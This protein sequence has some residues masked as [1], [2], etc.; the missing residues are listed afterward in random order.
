M[1]KKGLGPVIAIALLLVTTSLA[2]VSFQTWYDTYQ[3]N[4]FTD[5]ETQSNLA[6]NSQEL[7]IYNLIGSILYLKNSNSENITINKIK[8]DSSICFTNY[9]ISPGISEIDLLD[10][11]ENLT[12]NVPRIIIYTDTQILEKSFFLS[13]I[14]V[15]NLLSAPRFPSLIFT[16]NITSI[17]Y[18]GSINLSWTSNYADTCI[19]SVDWS[20]NQ[21]LSNSTIISN[22][23]STSTYTLSCTG[24]GGSI[25]RSVTINV[26][27]PPAPIL[28]FSV[29]TSGVDYGDDIN[30]SWISSNTDTCTA[31][32]NWSGIK[33]I[34]GT[35]IQI[36]LLSNSTYI[37]NCTGIGG[38]IKQSLTINVGSP[39][40]PLL[41]FTS[42]L[43]TIDY[44]SSVTLNWTSSN[45]DSCIASGDWVGAKAIS[46][47][48]T[49]NNLISDKT[50]ILN[51]MGVGG[52][53]SRSLTITVN[54]PPAP[55]L[56]FSADN[57]S[58]IYDSDI[59]LSWISSNTDTCTGSGDWSGA[60]V[61]SGSQN[62][63]NL[64]SSKTYVLNC[65]GIGGSIEQ[66]VTVNVANALD[67]LGPDSA[68][69][70][71][72]N[73]KTYYLTSSVAWDQTCSGES[74]S[75]SNGI[76]DGSNT[77]ASCSINNCPFG[78]II[79]LC[80]ICSGTSP[81]A[82]E[83]PSD[84]TSCGTIDC[85][86]L[87]NYQIIGTQGATTTSQCEYDNYADL[88][89]SRCELES[90]CKDANSADCGSPTTTT[91]ITAGVC[92][93]VGGCSG[94]TVGSLL[95]Y[96]DGTSC[97][98]SMECQSGSCIIAGPTF[99]SVWDTTKI[100]TG[101][102]ASTQ[103]ALPL[104]SDGTY[105]F[106][107][108]WGD[109]N[110][111]TITTWN[112]AEVIH[113]YGSEGIYEINITGT[114]KG[115]R[116][117]DGGDKL[118]LSDVQEWGALNLGNN[119][120]YFAGC[121]NLIGTATDALNLTGTTTLE[122][123]FGS[124]T[125]FNGAIGNWNVSNVINMEL[126]FIGA[127][128][129]NQDISNWDVSTVEDMTGMFIR[130][131][132]FDQNI[133]GWDVSNVWEMDIMFMQSFFD[134]D[135]SGWDVSGVDN[136]EMMFRDSFFDQDISGWDVSNVFFCMLFDDNSEP[137]WSADE[138]PTFTN[139]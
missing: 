69:I 54:L 136:M 128:S 111:N 67:C 39:P 88:T 48:E 31:S 32:G 66:S 95:N 96:A 15:I 101:S 5:L 30:L 64:L 23:L 81:V 83:M 57:T 86:G 90:D 123:A 107:V 28:S 50:Y 17:S 106:T 44:D 103:V 6:L 133:N 55:T 12:T 29:N 13:G 42:N 102:S 124:C 77:F 126:L 19:A 130:T 9:S 20:G 99:S 98:A 59:T 58:I 56:S 4:I 92:Q 84:D 60:K 80:S 122:G 118:K 112:Q 131:I 97:G 127:E 63:F 52:E 21:S 115:F 26:G 43:A 2:V 62:F 135:I 139:C 38:S 37:L 14:S 73:S 116:F 8:L 33:S 121:E 109:G 18:D 68:T 79:G 76:L 120:G 113:T 36:N 104:E 35:E 125:N 91:P 47:L 27:A 11:Y 41:S 74:R 132:D 3:T 40:A 7:E 24:I 61:L 87:D 34:S 94:G 82:T 75:C 105:D 119:N 65:S 70:L 138:K 72:E 108:N 10:C 100:S 117:N 51:C 49:L 78:S 53:I 45:T 16:S 137:S 85:D 114:I 71:H 89:S 93:Y 46:N 25:S 1:K 22:I 110:S 134:G 129:F